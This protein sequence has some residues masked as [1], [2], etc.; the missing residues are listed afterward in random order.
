MAEAAIRL[1]RHATLVV[2][3]AGVELLVDPMLSP[4][5]AND[6]VPNSPNDRRNPLVPLPTFDPSAPD[7]VVVTHTH[8]DHLDDAAAEA[9][10]EDRP[11]FCQP[12]DEG[13]VA[14]AGFSDVRPVEDAT[15]WRGVDL[16]RTGGRHGHGD[17]ADR[18]GPVSGFVLRAPDAPTVHVA[19]DT[20]WCA[21]LESAL[22]A[23]DPDAV[24]LNA[25]AAQFET[26][27]PITMTAADVARVVR[28][29]PD[30][31]VLAVH[32]DAVNHC[33]L[34]R[35]DLRAALADEGLGD[36]VTIPADGERVELS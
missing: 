35:E 26:G 20:V 15:A 9:V 11:V 12:A 5:G 34:T 23:H 32:M 2:E 3:Y 19:G 25:G 18:M 13:A 29:V 30:A 31:T 16:L 8:R 27:D 21:E 10:P 24:V 4:E 33:L 22:D 28:H 14:D 7:A 36:A 17:L 6:P 1:L